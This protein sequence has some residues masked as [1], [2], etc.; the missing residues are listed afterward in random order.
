MNRTR[1]L[2]RLTA[3][4]RFLLLWDDL[5]WATDI[6]ALAVVD[7]AGLLDSGGRVRIESVRRWLEPR[8]H[9][10]PHVRQLLYRP[11]W[12]LGWPLWVDAPSLNLA[13]HVRVH[14]V[15]PPG[16]QS[17]LLQA[18]AEL[19]SRRLDPAR[20]MWEVW[21]LP[22]LPQGRVGL[23]LRMH[24]T[25]ADGMAAVAAFGALLDSSADAP[26]PVS[27]SWTPTPMPTASELLRDNLGR[28]AHQLS[29]ALIGL[30]HASDTLHRTRR[31]WPAW[32]E[33][34]AE[35][36]APR[37]SLNRPVGA[38]RRLAILRSRLETITQIAHAH[39]AKVNDVVLA[40]V[41]GGLRELLSGRGEPVD[42]LT[43]R[44]VVPVS[45]HR[46]QRVQE[47]SGNQDGWMVVPLPLGEPDAVR[48]LDLIKLQT[49]ARK[50]HAHPQTGSGISGSI[51]LQ[52]AFL[53]GFARQRFINIPVT[54]IPGPTVPL[55][56][57]GAQLL[58]LF[59]VVS[60]MG[61]LALAVAVFSYNGQL[62]LTA[63]A[64]QNACPDVE[65]FIHGVNTAL[66]DLARSMSAP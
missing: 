56:L 66:N 42:R 52:R 38:D 58:E 5:G 17:R 3:S 55:Y 20:P 50:R 1:R 47:G 41:A 12:R 30:A 25:M 60:L 15:D 37:T 29:R 39:T 7:G 61:N 40:A 57:S 31:A 43:L 59:P 62:N 49:A 51:L 35:Q 46:E 53:H 27:P 26:T 19:A 13:D 18:C 8:L 14:P 23:F 33:L 65:V 36:R 22:G 48:R 16:D 4:D 11:R 32:R 21:L 10:L 64:D 44:A 6:G 54:N 9:S 2:E 63:I 45:L 24:H 28:Q 34:L